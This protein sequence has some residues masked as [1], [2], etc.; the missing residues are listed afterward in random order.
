MTGLRDHLLRR[1]E[2]GRVVFWLDTAAQYDTEMEGLDLPGVTTIRVANDEY[3]IKNR[4]L[5]D[6]PT[7]KFGS[8][9]LFAAVVR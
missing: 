3:A 4:L 1:F 2:K 5:H 9:A 8:P 7:S 6:E